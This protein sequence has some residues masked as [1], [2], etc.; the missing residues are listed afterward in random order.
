MLT[1]FKEFFDS[2]VQA[3]PLNF[4]ECPSEHMRVMWCYRAIVAQQ[5]QIA[6][7][8]AQILELRIKAGLS[9]ESDNNE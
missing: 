1:K 7:L 8:Q 4:M 5:A 3:A 6:V 9:K 2:I